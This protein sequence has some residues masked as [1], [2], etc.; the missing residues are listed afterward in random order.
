MSKCLTCSGT[1]FNWQDVQQIKQGMTTRQVTDILGQPYSTTSAGNR[2]T[3]TWVEVNGLT[4]KS[5]SVEI[6]FVN[7]K[8]YKV[9][10]VPSGSN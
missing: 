8:V 4:M 5:K 7:G 1:P 3:D 10:V 6:T 2:V 9:P